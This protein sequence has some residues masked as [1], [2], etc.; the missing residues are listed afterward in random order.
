VLD[1]G[2]ALVH[3]AVARQAERQPDAMALAC[4]DVPLTYAELMR[5]ANGVVAALAG[6]GIAPE[7]RVAVC[8]ERSVDVAVAIMGVLRAG[9]AYVS[10]E[11]S[12]PD[13]LLAFILEDSQASAVVTQQSMR[14]LPIASV[15]V[16]LVDAIPAASVSSG[17]PEYSNDDRLAYLIY[18]SGSTGQ[19][20]GVAVTHRNIASST[21]ARRLQYPDPSPRCLIIASAGFDVFSGGIFYAL[22]SGGA[23][24]MPGHETVRDPG[25]LASLIRRHGVTHWLGPWSMYAEVL[26]AARPG[27]LESLRIA[28]VGGEPCPP[29]L[30]EQHYVLLPNARLFNEYGPTEATVWSTVHECRPSGEQLVVPIGQPIAGSRVYVLD[31]ALQPVQAGEAGEIYIAGEGVARGYWR[32]PE[33]TLAKF[34]P[35]S[36]SQTAG[37]RMFRTGDIA[38]RRTDNALEFI[39]REDEQTKVNGHRVE[40]GQVENVLRTHRSVRE[41]VVLNFE[42]DGEQVLVAFVAL[43]TPTERAQSEC[44]LLRAHLHAHLPEY[45]APTEIT[46]VDRLPR[47]LNGKPD[48]QALASL[49]A[50]HRRRPTPNAETTEAAETAEAATSVTDVVTSIWRE[51]LKK[52]DIDVDDN[53]FDIGGH[54]MRLVRMASLIKQRLGQNIPIVTLL[55]HPTI[56]AMAA[57][58]TRESAA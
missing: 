3:D 8:V 2:L 29:R 57:Y 21:Q 26:A 37:E 30:V 42:D 53:F 47:T 28:M 10:L 13:S 39:G 41:G 35:D 54:S 27:E 15:P 23:A 52:D 22:S 44:G 36:V 46:V 9:C 40:L 4:D 11:P 48:R 5:R 33:L 34:L 50:A 31:R 14:P 32:S 51:V 16:V 25:R 43:D 7:S 12:H 1:Q 56:N 20:K 45:M 55:S 19:P 24:I 6:L 58:I 49:R 17:P 18:T 38:R